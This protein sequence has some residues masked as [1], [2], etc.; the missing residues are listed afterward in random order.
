MSEKTIQ[1]KIRLA[2]GKEEGVVLFR[3][4]TGAF[5]D[6][7]RLIRYGLAIGSSDLIGIVDGRFFALEVKQPGKKPTKEQ[8]QFLGCVRRHGGFA[9][10]VTSVAEA[11]A[12][13][14]RCRMGRSE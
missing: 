13:L 6:G 12:A 8:L 1:A 4:N 5:N 2:L 7:V 11:R 10:V 9:A 14:Q 3:N